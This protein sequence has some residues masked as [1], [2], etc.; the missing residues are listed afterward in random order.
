MQQQVRDLEMEERI[1]PYISKWKCP[2]CKTEIR[3]I[4]VQ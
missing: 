2:V 3:D 4:L 1:L